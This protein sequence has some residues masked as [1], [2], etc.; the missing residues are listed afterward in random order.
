M[1]FAVGGVRRRARADRV[2]AD[3]PHQDR[4]AGRDA[5]RARR[6]A[7]S[8]A[9][10][11]GGRL[12]HDR[13]AGRDDD[14]G[15][16]HRDH[17][18]LYVAGDPRRPALGRPAAGCR[19]LARGDHR[20]AVGVSGQR[21]D[22]PVDRPDHVPARRR[23][24]HRPGAAADHRDRRLQHRRHGDADRRPAQHPD[25]RAHRAVVRRVHRQPGAG[26]DRRA[27]ARDP[28]ALPR[29]SQAPADRS[30]G[31]QA[32]ARARCLRVD[33]GPAPR[34]VAPCRS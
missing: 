25:R 33:R 4:A 13:P 2:G 31:A 30:G 20:G 16:G 34:R 19:G 7:R 1:A 23:A 29:V 5:G 32:R 26:R 17:G 22:D 10:D 8:G 28:G 21:D 12:Q 9:G 3:R 11:R 6:H 18:R 24:R 14:H 15:P 27:R